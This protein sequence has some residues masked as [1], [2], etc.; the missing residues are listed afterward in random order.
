MRTVTVNHTQIHSGI[1][2]VKQLETTQQMLT[3]MSY[4]GVCMCTHF[5]RRGEDAVN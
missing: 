3:S 2:C 1:M 4:M 5:S